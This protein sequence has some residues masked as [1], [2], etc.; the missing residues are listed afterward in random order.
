LTGQPRLAG[1]GAIAVAR[2]QLPINTPG[3]GPDPDKNEWKMAAIGYPLWPWAE[4]LTHIGPDGQNVAGLSVSLDARLSKT[5]FRMGDGKAVRCTGAGTCYKNWV[6]PGVT[7]PNCG[8]V[9]EKPS[10]PNKKY[11]VV[12]TSYWDVTWTVNGVSG[13]IEVPRQGS[14]GLPAGELQAV[15]VR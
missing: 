3:I 13:V 8:D 6:Q 15:L 2:L 5:V 14:V 7:S 1:A 10:L 4:G 9:Y 12:A 11:R